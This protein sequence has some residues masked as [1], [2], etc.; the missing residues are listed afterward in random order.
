MLNE[1]EKNENTFFVVLQS[2][3]ITNVYF[4]DGPST[5]WQWIFMPYTIWKY[6]SNGRTVSASH[7]G[8]GVRSQWIIK[9]IDD[10]DVANCNE[11]IVV[12][13]LYFCA[14]NISPY[15]NMKKYRE[16]LQ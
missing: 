8:T 3:D 1:L 12:K 6:A 15:L 10:N 2:V 5:V 13:S 7:L 11:N 14:F 9:Y 16:N 4:Y